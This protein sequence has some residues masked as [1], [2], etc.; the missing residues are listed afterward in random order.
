MPSQNSSSIS[1]FSYLLSDKGGRRTG[2]FLNKMDKIVPW[3][4]IGDELAPALYD[5]HLG[6]PGFPVHI[7]I[8]ALFL[9]LWYCLSDPELEEQVLDRVS[10]Q[11]FLEVKDRNDIPDETTVC[12]F[13]AKLVELG[14]EKELFEVVSEMIDDNGLKINKGTIVDATIIDAPKGRKR[15][16]GSNT[17]D[18]DAGF[19]KKGGR[20]FHGYKIHVA[21][22][23][24]GK[25]INKTVI[26][27]ATVQDCSIFDQLTEKENK[28]V[29]AD[30]AY[31]NKEKKNKFR[32]QGIYWGI[33]DKNE[34]YY[35]LSKKQEKDNKQKSSVRCRVEHVFAWMKKT[36][37][38]RNVRFRGLQ[39]NT[40]HLTMISAA[41]NLRR[42]ASVI[43][44]T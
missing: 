28:A 32:K 26:T 31:V 18:K 25:F 2:A 36:M 44:D 8:K 23:V 37:K 4:E 13:R 19:T 21:S 24:S 43:K 5:G 7:L 9:E 20:S 35:K 3:K 42:L 27:S 38:L 11:R 12:R 1:M 22:D 30:K 14:A 41:Y 6:R 39:R 16:N 40:F 34:R 29:Y 33:L 15:D 17:R 10:F